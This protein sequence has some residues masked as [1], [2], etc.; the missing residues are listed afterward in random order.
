MKHLARQVRCCISLLQHSRKAFFS[1][2]FLHFVFAVWS[3]SCSRSVCSHFATTYIVVTWNACL[4]PLLLRVCHRES[5]SGGTRRENLWLH[6]HQLANGSLSGAPCCR[7]HLSLQVHTTDSLIARSTCALP[8]DMT[9]TS[10]TFT[11][12]QCLTVAY[13]HCLISSSIS[14]I[15]FLAFSFSALYLRSISCTPKNC[16]NFVVALP[17]S[18]STVISIH[19]E[20][21]LSF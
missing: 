17:L 9:A 15:I 6:Q 12:H 3:M 18:P 10:T 1:S 7:P 19:C 2:V 5:I 11:D 20:L 13:R 21:T 16:H 4:Q 14:R 8:F